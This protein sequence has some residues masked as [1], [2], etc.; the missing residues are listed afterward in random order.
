MPYVSV[1]LKN[2]SS[3]KPGHQFFELSLLI[4][5]RCGYPHIQCIGVRDAEK[6]SLSAFSEFCLIHLPLLG[7]DVLDGWSYIATACQ[8]RRYSAILKL[9]A[10]P[11]MCYKSEMF[12]A[13]IVGVY[14]NNIL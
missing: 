6:T 9:Q 3:V 13:C 2:S 10:R 11:T 5:W 4:T 1:R 8:Q 14:G 12:T 7:V